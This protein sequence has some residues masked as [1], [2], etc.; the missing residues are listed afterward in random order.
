MA[1][2][3]GKGRWITGDELIAFINNEEAIRPDGTKGPGLFA[4]LRSLQSSNG[5]IAVM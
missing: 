4:Y 2:L 3:G 1:R 5:G